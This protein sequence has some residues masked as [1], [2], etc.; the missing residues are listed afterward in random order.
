[1]TNRP[2]KANAPNWV[3][4]PDGE[5]LPSYT[6]PNAPRYRNHAN[7]QFSSEDLEEVHPMPGAVEINPTEIIDG[8]RVANNLPRAAD[9]PTD[10]D[11][12]KGITYQYE[13]GRKDVLGH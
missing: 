10:A 12:N 11:R 13:E 3:E 2:D 6:G 7:P 5:I 4:D 9:L 1:M 8:I